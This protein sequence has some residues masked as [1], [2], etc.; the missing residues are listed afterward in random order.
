MEAGARP[1]S[2]NEPPDP[3]LIGAARAEFEAH[4]VELSHAHEDSI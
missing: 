1:V 2:E 3:D 4:G